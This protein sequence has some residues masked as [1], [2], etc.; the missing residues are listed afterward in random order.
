M[1]K[2]I[3]IDTVRTPIGTLT[4]GVSEEGRAVFLLF[5]GQ[6]PPPGCLRDP[7]RC[8]VFKAELEEYFAGKRKDFTVPCEYPGTPFAVAV[9]KALAGVPYGKTITYGE[10][11]AQAGHP[12]AARAVGTVMA[13]NPLPIIL[14]CHRVL[15]SG[16]GVGNFGGGQS[17]KNFLL[18]LEARNSA[19]D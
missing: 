15:P 13:K 12:R 10:L 17:V 4:L 18:G 8:S 14:P 16:G 5:D 1:K 3:N 19:K 7:E 9:L 6:T 2:I 11:A